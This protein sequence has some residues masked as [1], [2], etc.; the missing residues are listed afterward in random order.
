M[1][2]IDK[3]A[4]NDDIS[5]LLEASEKLNSQTLSLTRCVILALLSYFVDGIQFRELKAALKIS[6]GKLIS[7]LKIL[8]KLGYIEKSEV[9]VDRKKID[10]YSLSP[11]GRKEVSKIIDWMKQVEILSKEGNEKCQAILT[12]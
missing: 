6:D 1:Q 5:R 11:N 3:P 12:K 9:E 10:V 4:V 2:S 7:N 8:K